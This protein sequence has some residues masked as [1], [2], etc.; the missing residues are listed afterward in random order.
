MNP[1]LLKPEGDD[2]SQLVV[3]GRAVGSVRWREY[4]ARQAGARARIAE[5]LERLRAAHDVV[6]IE[7]AGSP[8]EINLRDAD[9]VNMHV[10]RLAEAPVLLIGD[11]DRGGVF[12]ALVGTLAL[13]SPDDRARVAGLIIN[14]CAATPR[15]WRPGLQELQAL[16]G[17]PV[18]GVVPW[19]EERLM[20]A[21]D[22]LDLDEPRS[23]RRPGHV[24]ID[25]A[26]VRL[27]R[28]ANFDDFEWLA[29]E[30]GVRVRWV[31]SPGEL[32]DA[33][34][35]VLPGS[36]STWPIWPGC[37]S[38]DW[39]IDRGRRPRGRPCSVSV[40]A[41]RCSAAGCTIPRAWSRR[42][43]G[44]GLDLL[45]VATT[46]A[47]DK[48]TVRV[49]PAPGAAPG[50]FAAAAATPATYEIHAGVTA[51]V[52]RPHRRPFA[53][54]ERGG[55]AAD[56]A[57]RRASL[58]PC[59]ARTCT[60]AAPRRRCAVAA[61]LAGRA[62]AAAAHRGGGARRALHAGTGLA[63]IV[64]GALDVAAIGSL[65]GRRSERSCRPR[66]TPSSSS[67]SPWRGSRFRRSRPTAGIPWRGSAARSPRRARWFAWRPVRLFV[68][69]ARHP[70]RDGGRGA[71]GWLL[72]LMLGAR[73]G[74][75]SRSKPRAEVHAGAPWPRPR[76]ARR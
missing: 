30:P 60:G 20:P 61:G 75:A 53:I 43:R 31:R 9:L 55:L 1:I 69:G 15:C 24:T 58:A 35:I 19:I 25:I 38:E 49:R 4:T 39:P 76:R 12:A 34:L 3:R 66:C 11:I 57:G 22:S 37:A 42:G 50:P 73:R 8:A 64:G 21:E 48:T 33:D 10:A 68:A 18:L 44:A 67:C 29:D 54:V 16:T 41:I 26:V 62:R 63:D 23:R 5:S 27:P 45:P 51:P 36:K 17:L 46:F 74:R 2:R 28:I 52:A 47:R 7:G 70:R 65:V 14:R 56:G 40:A 59:A 13:L 32:G 72:T 6:I 71:G